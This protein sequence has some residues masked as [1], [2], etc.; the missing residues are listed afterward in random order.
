M[1]Y[2]L[3]CIEKFEELDSKL[4]E[5]FGGDK[6][7]SLVEEL[8][9]QFEVDL[10]FVLILLAINELNISD[11]PE[12]LKKKYKLSSEKVNLIVE[13]IEENII[14]LVDD[15]ILERQEEKTVENIDIQEIIM[16]VFSE[17]LLLIFSY[18]KEDIKN[19]NIATFAAF[20]DLELLEEKVI[21]SFYNNQEL[22]SQE[23]IIIEDKAKKATIANFLQDFIK[24]HGSD[25]PDNLILANYLN[26]S[27]NVKK[28]NETEK[29]LLNR[30][31]KTY[32][33]LV[34]FP[35]SMEGVPMELWEIIP[36]RANNKEV[37]DVLDDEE[38]SSSFKEN[39][40][41][42]IID[43]EKT[44]PKK[45]EKL[46]KKDDLVDLKN[47]KEKSVSE[48][49]KLMKEYQNGSLEYKAIKQELNRLQK[50]KK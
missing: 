29:N 19:F 8:E 45:P 23:K 11:L 41:K 25:M 31:L 3:E 7:N 28:L 39:L 48:L 32:R 24:S 36:V 21:D 18:P 50:N 9:N 15:Y 17:N 27:A 26:T 35:E 49:K 46:I 16:S 2:T 12:Y 20:N 43:N 14:K 30:V 13:E 22:I 42:K 33:N 37:L 6:A 44:K 47:I 34:F 38:K 4:K 5:I 10:S 40:K 1:N